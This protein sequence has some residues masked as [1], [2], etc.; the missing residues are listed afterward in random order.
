[1]KRTT[2]QWQQRQGQCSKYNIDNNDNADNDDEDNNEDGYDNGAAAAASGGW[3]R[4]GRATNAAAVGVE[5][6]FFYQNWILGVVGQ[7]AGEAGRREAKPKASTQ[8]S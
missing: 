6:S 8:K 1:V 3:R 5:C 2:R 4:R 7:G